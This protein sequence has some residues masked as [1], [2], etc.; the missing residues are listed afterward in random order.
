MIDISS[1]QQCSPSSPRY[2]SI[3]QTLFSEEHLIALAKTSG[4]IKRTPRKIDA[5]GLLTAIFAE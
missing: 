1:S 5:C 3:G 2:I 4:F